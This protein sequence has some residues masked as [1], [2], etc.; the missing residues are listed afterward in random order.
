[1]NK[2]DILESIH[3]KSEIDDETGCRIYQGATNQNEYGRIYYNGK[4]CSVHRVMYQLYIGKI[5]PGWDV[6]HTCGRRACCRIEHLRAIP[7][8]LNVAC[9][10]K[11]ENLRLARMRLLVATEQSVR[12]SGMTCLTSRRLGD[13]WDCRSDNV[14]VVLST[15]SLTC[16]GF[17]WKIALA[18]RGRRPT[19]YTI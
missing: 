6:H 17:E 15:M 7:H 16:D 2:S 14:P 12:E 3:S 18:G 4:T 10:Q 19:L 1:M 9:I 13:L 11:Y 8:R 5:P